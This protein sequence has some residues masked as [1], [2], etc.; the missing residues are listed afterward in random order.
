MNN[1]YEKPQ[2]LNNKII[3]DLYKE[4]I[5]AHNYLIDLKRV[6]KNSFYNIGIKKITNI[7]I[8]RKKIILL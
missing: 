6:K 4:L 2:L 1:G 5:D 3:I 8:S 7:K